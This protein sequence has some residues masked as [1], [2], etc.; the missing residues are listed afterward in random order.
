MKGINFRL[1]LVF[2]CTA[3]SLLILQSVFDASDHKKGDHA[4]RDYRVG[5]AET[6]S[7]FLEA[8]APAG[9]WST[10]ITHS[11]RGVVRVTYATPQKSYSFDYEVP[12]HAIHPGDEA[13][14]DVLERFVRKNGKPADAPAPSGAP[15]HN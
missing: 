8:E 9:V 1:F 5:S 14:R 2:F 13:G 7:A 11:C 6:L 3:G 12:A 4:V 10:E 15:Q